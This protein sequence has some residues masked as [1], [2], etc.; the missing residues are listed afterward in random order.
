MNII[1]LRTENIKNI[2]AIEITP[3]GQNVTLE[4]KNGAGKSAVLDS[5]MVALSGEKL[6]EPIRQGTNKAVIDVDLGEYKVKRIITEKTDRLEVTNAAGAKFPSPQAL[7][8]KIIGKICF[9]P[10][11]FAG[12]KPPEQHSFI[13]RLT[14]IDL[15]AFR[16]KKDEL[17]FKRTEVNR[18][19]KEKETILGNKFFVKD[20]PEELISLSEISNQISV[21]RQAETN[22]QYYQN[23][24]ADLNNTKAKWL[25]D[26][27]RLQE[28]IN[29]FKDQIKDTDKAI[30]EMTEPPKVNP[31]EITALTAKINTA[32]D[33]NEQIRQN[34]SYLKLKS[35]VE[36][37]KSEQELI[38]VSMDGLQSDLNGRIAASKLPVEGL[39][40]DETG[41]T[42]A[43]KPFAQL[44][45]GEQ[46]RISTL[47]A[48]AFNPVL[49]IIIIKEG[50]LLD[51][52]GKKAIF[53]IANKDGYQVWIEEVKDGKNVGIYIEDGAIKE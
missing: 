16:R 47:I 8:D 37:I 18:R 28:Q 13:A 5:I 19:L 36:A 15:V 35:E 42:F 34:Q 14:G 6:T 31:E 40:I 2:K 7:L 30:S 45:T 12:M 1:K 21:L 32:E 25:K 17:Y 33:T 53:D 39:S 22:Y 29:I 26:I 41:V 46:I 10:L 48:M 51:N 9:D 49:K 23:K 38:G 20:L 50:S 52:A 4:G 44:S 11:S 24:I 3:N 43:G 27:E